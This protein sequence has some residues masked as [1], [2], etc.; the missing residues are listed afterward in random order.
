MTDDVQS[1]SGET[2]TQ[3]VIV[4]PVVVFILMLAIQA[5]LYFHISHVAGAAAAQGASAASEK[6]LSAGEA[7]RRGQERAD[8]MVRET[9][10]ILAGPTR[11]AVST[12]EVRV[13]VR[14]AV[15]RI[16]PLFPAQAVRTAVEPRE[17]F[18]AEFLR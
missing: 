13:T 14:T 2:T 18:I 7:A 12:E 6:L 3:A 5:A 10:T 8:S 15:P 1:D 17:R 16:I 9:G 4:L 11:V